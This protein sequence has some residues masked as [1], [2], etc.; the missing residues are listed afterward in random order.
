MNA[1]PHPPR[2]EEL[3]NALTHGVG[4]L[5]SLV[6]LP[7]LVLAALR[8]ADL[9]QVVG[10]SVYG[11]T[12][13]MLYGA[14]TA[15]HALSPSPVKAVLRRID[16]SAIYLLIAGTYTPFALGPLRGAWGWALLGTV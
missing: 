15:Y 3:A 12:L 9:M 10:S 1:E 4:L 6:A 2:I 13:V 8:R 14:S 5:A 11:A 7:I 16:H